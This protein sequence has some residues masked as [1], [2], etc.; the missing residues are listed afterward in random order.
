MHPV[1]ILSKRELSGFFSTLPS[2]LFLT[3]FV[4]LSGFLPFYAGRFFER[5]LADLQ[6]FFYFQPALLCL[7]V[8]VWT[9]HAFS[10]EEQTG[11]LEILQTLPFSC[12]QLILGKFCAYATLCLIALI[13]TVPFWYTVNFLGAPDNIAVLTGYAGIFLTAC[14]FVAVSLFFSVCTRSASNAFAGA[15]IACGVCFYFNA[16]IVKKLTGFSGLHTDFINSFGINA[17][18]FSLV[19]GLVGIYDFLFFI[20]FTAFWLTAAKLILKN[21]GLPA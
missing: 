19:N 21:K 16:D 8:P 14:C 13:L 1:F 15:L 7:F 5:S 2:W 20:S 10:F 18:L 17:H 9:A 4:L 3:A 11:S 6:P 12:T